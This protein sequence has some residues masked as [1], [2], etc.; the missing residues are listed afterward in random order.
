M[1]LL[2]GNCESDKFFDEGV[3]VSVGNWENDGQWIPLKFFASSLMRPPAHRKLNIDI[4]PQNI[5]I[6]P[7][8]QKSINIRGY[9]VPIVMQNNTNPLYVNFSVCGN[10][11][12]R[13]GVQFRWLQTASVFVTSVYGNDI[14]DVWT[15]NSVSTS[16]PICVSKNTV[17]G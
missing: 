3:E 14:R 6:S 4:D 1:N 8:A 5:D 13:S 10:D 12:V 11:I 17:Q 7:F 16:N 15:M 9:T 2:P